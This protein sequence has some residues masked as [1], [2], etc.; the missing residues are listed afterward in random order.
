VAI[1][2]SGVYELA[3]RYC[4][5]DSTAFSPL[6]CLQTA[7]GQRLEQLRRRAIILGSGEGDYESPADSKRIADTCVS[8]AIPCRLSLWGPR[9]DHTWSTW[10]E[11]LPRLLD[12]QLANPLRGPG[13]TGQAP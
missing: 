2:L 10:R 1:G 4:D 11:M 9:R 6:A 12:E 5:E 7:K 8:K 13:A 3:P